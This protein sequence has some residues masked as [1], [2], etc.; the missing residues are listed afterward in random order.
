VILLLPAAAIAAI[1]P[2]AGPQPVAVFIEQN[3][4]LMVI[5]SDVPRVAVYENGDVIFE[6]K[7]GNDYSLRIAHLSPADLTRLEAAWAPLF[8]TKLRTNYELSDATDQTNAEFFFRRGNRQVAVSAYGLNCNGIAFERKLTG[9]AVPPRALLQAHKTLCNVDFKQS[10]IWSPKYVEVMLW[11]YSYAPDKP[12][13]WP[14]SW[15]NLTS[16][17]AIKRGDM[18]SI[19][20]DGSYLPELKA[21]LKTRREKGAVVVV[22]KK[23]VASYRFT[24]PS[25]PVWRKALTPRQDKE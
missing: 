19:F 8:A 1:N 18:W 3:P 16:K 4:W 21:F 24:F 13:Y 6:K 17:R 5:G 25:E 23:W 11:D 14:K 22:G 7:V 9:D 20:L 2:F 10:E 15:P 12:I